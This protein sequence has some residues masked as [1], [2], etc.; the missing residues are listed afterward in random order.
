MNVITQ[1]E[2]GRS[3]TRLRDKAKRLW[4]TPE[5]DQP[6]QEDGSVRR[7]PQGDGKGQ[8]M[9]RIPQRAQSGRESADHH[10]RRLEKRISQ[11][12]L[13]TTV[14]WQ[15]VE[16][17]RQQLLRANSRV[18][19]T[20]GRLRQVEADARGLEDRLRESEQARREAEKRA[21]LA[22][23]RATEA[24][25]FR[26]EEVR[27]A[28]RRA[29]FAEGQL[30]R[31]LGES[32]HLDVH[33]KDHFWVVQRDEIELTAEQLGKGGW[34][35]VYIAKFRGLNV[36]AKHLHGLIVSDYNRQ[37]FMREM[38]IAA[39]LQHPNLIQFLG[40]TVEGTPVILTE[41]MET[42]L[43][44]VLEQRALDSQEAA[45]LS[46]DIARALNY[47][48]LIRPDPIIHRDISSANVL[49]EAAPNNTWKTKVA[50]LGSANF[51]KHISTAGPGSPAY[52]APEA[53]DPSRQSPKMDVYSYGILLLEMYTR[54]FP[55]TVDL[56]SQLDSIGQPR[57]VRL[58]RECIEYNPKG[59]PTMNTIVA[60]LQ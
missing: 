57:V 56:T 18:L 20:E 42:S 51:V 22:E 39:R 53:V 21:S 13:E 50:D 26:Q 44:A 29:Q 7:R 25:Q 23:T 46:L 24:T 28:E 1:E 36:A 38:T 9:A 40:A 15:E 48:H 30:R 11:A 52:A 37:L 14:A 55:E 58:I 43:R 10:A 19:D 35:V 47:L 45:G 3:A 32:R 2:L 33:S 54:R 8:R 5:S 60:Q 31:V 17:L 34:G 16:L 41:L 6:S 4:N 12:E 49:L 59:R 27:E